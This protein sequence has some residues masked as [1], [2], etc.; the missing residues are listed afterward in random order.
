MIKEQA[1]IEAYSY[2]NE[3]TG[4]E[5]GD[6]DYSGDTL[7]LLA[8][9]VSTLESIIQDASGDSPTYERLIKTAIEVLNSYEYKE[10]L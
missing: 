2:L 6:V 5:K 4:E 7:E 9:G 8:L 10:E 3:R 1:K